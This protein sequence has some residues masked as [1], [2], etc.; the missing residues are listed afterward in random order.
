M[1]FGNN[2]SASS[3]KSTT[4]KLLATLAELGGQRVSTDG[5]KF[6]GR[7]LILPE[8]MTAQ[9][10]VKFLRDY[11]Q[12]QEE[13]TRYSRIYRFR[14]WDGAHALQSAMKKVFGTTGIQKAQQSF[15]G[16]TPPEQRTI[17]TGPDETTQVPWGEIQV[18][19]FEGTM[20]LHGVDD[21]EFG[22]LFALVVD[23]P[24][25]FQAHVEGLFQMVQDEL[26][27]HSIYRGQAIDGQHD[28]EFLDLD[29]VDP[30]KVVYSEEVQHQLSANVWALL[31]HTGTH[32]ELDLPLKRSVLLEGP[33]GTGKTLA[34]FLTAKVAV[35]NGWT[36]VYCRPGRDN[37]SEVMST[38]RL[39]QPS[40]VFF[41][42][43]DTISSTGDDGAVTRL[44][45]LFD[46][47]N[48]KGTELLAVM[49]TNHPERI[50]KG[51]VRPGRLDAVIHVGALDNPGVE[52]LIKAS[53]QQEL[54]SDDVDFTRVSEAMEGYLP[55]YVK[56]AIDRSVRYAIERSGGK[57][58]K[59]TTDDFVLAANGLRSQLELQEQAKE[60]E[61]K[62]TLHTVLQ[63][64]VVDGLQEQ[65]IIREEKRDATLDIQRKVLATDV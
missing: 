31:R 55:A 12:A 58:E 1:S 5:L 14:P 62:P 22:P 34:A 29:G 26:E 48:A 43:V 16:T 42:D 38:A 50:H 13:P 40:V 47:I 41:E 19:I 32:R 49:T 11:I 8:T 33:Y 36:F 60:G 44:L 17:K 37:I 27:N 15:F 46:G 53:V 64:V 10:A 65:A 23:A 63:E 61:H 45:D 25:K 20:T 4:K 9:Q 6:Q 30:Q 21:P 24:K 28:A 18:P 39:Y 3:H 35:Q 57:P 54:L 2:P 52:A 56:E 51:M 7:E 59:L